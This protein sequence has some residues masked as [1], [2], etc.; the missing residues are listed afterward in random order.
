VTIFLLVDIMA[1]AMASLA[2]SITTST[3]EQ[4]SSTGAEVPNI[5]VEWLT[6][7]QLGQYARGFLDNGYDELETV[8]KIGPADL[9]AIGVLSAHHRAFLL[10]AVRVLKE[11]GAA[12]V[13]LLLGAPGG[14]TE[15]CSGEDRVSA[16]S[17]IASGT[18]SQ[19]WIDDQELSASSCECDTS[20]ASRRSR[21]NSLKNRRRSNNFNVRNNNNV[22]GSTKAQIYGGE[23]VRG[24]PPGSPPGRGSAG[25]TSSRES[26][27]SPGMNTAYRAMVG[28]AGNRTPS[29]GQSCVTETT[30]CPSD[31]SV[32]TSISA[33][34]LNGSRTESNH[35]PT[36]PDTAEDMPGSRITYSRSEEDLIQRVPSDHESRLHGSGDPRQYNSRQLAGLDSRH[37]VS[38][39]SV[40]RVTLPPSTL[41][42]LVRERLREH[43]ISLSTHPY[44]Q[45]SG[46]SSGYLASLAATLADELRTTF[47]DVLSQL[48]DLRLAEWSDQAPPPPSNPRHGAGMQRSCVNHNYANYPQSGRSF[49]ESEPIYQPG[50]YAPSSCMHEGD[51]D[52]IYDFAAKYRT[53]MRAQQAKMLMTPQGWLQMAKKIIS[54]SKQRDGSDGNNRQMLNAPKNGGKGAAVRQ[55]G[56]PAART[57]NGSENDLSLNYNSVP[58]LYS[59]QFSDDGVGVSGHNR[60]DLMSRN[61]ELNGGPGIRYAP[62]GRRGSPEVEMY[63]TRVIY[64]SRQDCSDIHSSV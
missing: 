57:F 28:L 49:S 26:Q 52:E 20:S 14:Q 38:R 10:D 59:G 45:S 5:V 23:S 46:D 41:R 35:Q 18:S 6:F 9:D 39:R 8:K 47:Q 63:K 33:V 29:I 32:I 54:K 55:N 62:D 24:E 51:T 53:Q 1:M 58:R 4:T 56:L 43:G 40:G 22:T 11:Q 15:A 3:G 13:Y 30:D 50:A 25:S 61:S 12:W 44:T 60:R 17:G 19:P 7:L 42:D 37:L 27:P 64:H 36:S 34:P 2:P 31:I 16:S 48:E 21:R